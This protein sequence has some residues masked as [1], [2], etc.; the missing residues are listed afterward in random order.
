MLS[1]LALILVALTIAPLWAIELTV[2]GDFRT[3]LFIHL[4][5]VVMFIQVACKPIVDNVDITI[6]V[7]YG[8]PLLLGVIIGLLSLFLLLNGLFLI[9]RPEVDSQEKILAKK[10]FKKATAIFLLVGF[11]FAGVYQPIG[12]LFISI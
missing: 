11:H 5:K 4:A 6:L 2:E 7:F 3:N 1:I 10:F 9:N 8:I 12:S